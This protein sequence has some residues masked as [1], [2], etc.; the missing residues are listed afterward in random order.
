MANGELTTAK[1]RRRLLAEGDGGLGPLGHEYLAAG[2]WGEA[3]ECLAAAQDQQGL[4]ELAQQAQEAGDWFYW[5]AAL[6]AM[7][8]EPSPEEQSQVAAAAEASG[9]NAFARSAAGQDED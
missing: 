8:Q 5:R 2:R 4:Q 3:L 1:K 9:K 7:G 6:T